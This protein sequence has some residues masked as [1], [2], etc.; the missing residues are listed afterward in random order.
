[1][2][3]TSIDKDFTLR[4]QLKTKEFLILNDLPV[5]H[6]MGQQFHGRLPMLVMDGKE[7]AQIRR[8]A[9]SERVSQYNKAH[10]QPPGLE[11]ILVGDDPASQVY[12]GGKEK[13]S[14]KVGTRS[15]VP[16]LPLHDH[17]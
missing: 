10:G 16:S 13:A 4:N 12:V 9:L 17:Q 5:S 8:Q 15:P 7:V 6:L 2:R 1:V 14:Q 11:V 3:Q